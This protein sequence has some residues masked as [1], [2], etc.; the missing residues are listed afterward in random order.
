MSGSIQSAMDLRFRHDE[1]RDVTILA[2]RRAGGLCHV[3]K[4]Y[5]NGRT[6][7]LQLVNPTAGIF[8][9]D[10]LQMRIELEKNARATLSCPSANRFHAMKNASARIEQDFVVGEGAWLDFRPEWVIPQQGSEVELVTRIEVA[11]GGRLV[12]GDLLAPG[13][14]AHGEGLDF[15]FFGTRFELRVGGRLVVQERMELEPSRGAW[16]FKVPGWEHCFYGA[17]W[18]VNCPLGAEEIAR[19]ESLQNE[20][21]KIGVSEL[22]DKVMVIR[23]LAARSLL[24]KKSSEA[25]R[26]ELALLFPLLSR[27]ERL[28]T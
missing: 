16:P 13:R 7:A 15:R 10:E 19:I 20:G 11:E 14:V 6:L 17:W 1:S 9:G 22:D 28:L 27:E 2:E 23:L 3:S 18:L 26:E 12:F 24:L 5:W 8:G 4:P 21:L 25:L